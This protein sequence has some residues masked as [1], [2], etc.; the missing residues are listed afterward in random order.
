MLEIAEF[1]MLALDNT[2]W[3]VISLKV[4]AKVSPGNHSIPSRV[5]VLL[6]PITCLALE[7][8]R[9]ELAVVLTPGI[10]TFKMMVDVHEPIIG[11]RGLGTKA[12]GL[13]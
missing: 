4:L 11:V 7:L 3:N 12:K 10:A 6:I 9:S 1:L 5:F 13:W 2:C 8:K